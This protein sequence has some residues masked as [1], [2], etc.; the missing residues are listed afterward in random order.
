LARIGFGALLSLLG[1]GAALSLGAGVRLIGIG[2]LGRPRT[3]RAAAAEEAPRPVL[4][5]MALLALCV[6]PVALLPGLILLGLQPVIATLVP[7]AP[8]LALGYQPLPIAFLLLI[9][10]LA[11]LALLQR[12]G[13]RGEREVPAWT[14]GFGAPPVWLPFGDPKTQPTAT[15]FAEPVARAIGDAIGMR[16]G[17]DPGDTWLFTPLFRLH[18]RLTRLAERIRR[19]TIR[20]RLAFV[21]AA[22]VVFLLVLGLDQDG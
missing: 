18:L 10:T 22:L 11:A 17:A 14:G 16:A 1:L 9:A 3:L 8:R 19:A 5:G 2:F 7:G 4:I 13:A 20:Q 15:G 21:F 6:V 12:F